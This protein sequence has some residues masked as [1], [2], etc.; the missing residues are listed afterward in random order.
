MQVEK[1]LAREKELRPLRGERATAFILLLPAGRNHRLRAR[2]AHSSTAAS[3]QTPRGKHPTWSGVSIDPA[4]QNQTFAELPRFCSS[5][6][7]PTP[8]A[9]WWDPPRLDEELRGV[10]WHRGARFD[11][12]RRRERVVEEAVACRANATQLVKEVVERSTQPR[13]V[14]VTIDRHGCERLEQ[15][16]RFAPGRSRAEPAGR[17]EV[18]YV[19]PGRDAGPRRRPHALEPGTARTSPP[20]RATRSRTGPGRARDRRRLRAAETTAAGPER[21]RPVRRP[22]GARGRSRRSSA[23]SSTRRPA[24]PT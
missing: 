5:R 21:D 4:R 13:S 3:D 10:R 8:A 12:A 24:A 9:S 20:A 17:Q 16:I 14:E 11:R 15:R 22:A 1:P 2:G 19:A 7:S 6:L 23:T 18:L